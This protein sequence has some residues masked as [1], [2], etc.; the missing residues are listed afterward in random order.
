MKHPLAFLRPK[1]A[2]FE[3]DI[4][5]TF[6][7]LEDLIERAERIT[8]SCVLLEQVDV[9]GRF[10]KDVAIRGVYSKKYSPEEAKK[11]SIIVDHMVKRKIR[12]LYAA[13]AV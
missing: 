3:F 11:V 4:R 9:S 13:D 12:T 10:I 1:R 2:R 8:E 7:P 6:P 5:P